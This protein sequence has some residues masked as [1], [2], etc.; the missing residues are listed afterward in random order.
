MKLTE[1]TVVEVDL[2]KYKDLIE[3]TEKECLKTI[4]NS[5]KVFVLTLIKNSTEL[6]ELGDTNEWQ[7]DLDVWKHVEDNYLKKDKTGG[8]DTKDLFKIVYTTLSEKYVK[9]KE[10]TKTTTKATASKTV[11][12]SDKPKE[13]TFDLNEGLMGLEI[14]YDKKTILSK[15]QFEAKIKEE[16]G[17]DK[18]YQF[19]YGLNQVKVLIK[20][21]SKET[22]EEEEVKE[23]KEDVNMYYVEQ[24]EKDDDDDEDQFVII[25]PE[26]TEL[27]KDENDEDSEP[28]TFDT[29]EEA[30]QL[31]KELN[32]SLLEK[33]N[34]DTKPKKEKKKKEPKVKQ[35]KE[36]EVVVEKEEEVKE[37]VKEDV[38]VE[39]EKKEEVKEVTVEA[40]DEDD[41]DW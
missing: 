23:T 13:L 6:Q 16:N 25:T 2:N 14:Q 33:L 38:K 9:P 22:K 28:L 41:F 10:P 31:V 40:D 36:E 20:P 30:E 15:S 8:I 12:R 27:P 39:K 4:N 34:G 32:R 21:L 3:K 7:S 11:S 37:E 35:V 26:K 1:L 18:E 29:E 5:P 19:E 17:E 24:L